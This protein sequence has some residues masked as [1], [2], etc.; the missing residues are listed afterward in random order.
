M[1]SIHINSIKGDE[2]LAKSVY[3]EDGR[4]LLRSGTMIRSTYIK[5]L[6]EM[7]IEYL[8]IQDADTEGIN[9]EEL[10]S[11]E[12]KQQGKQEVKKVFKDYIVS[13]RLELTKIYD[14]VNTIL[15]E[16]LN[17]KDT[18]FNVSDLR[19]KNE[20][21]YEHCMSVCILATSVGAYVFDT[22]KLR[23]LTL[24]A[25]LHDFGLM[26]VP[27]EIL[28]KPDKLSPEEFDLIKT[29]PQ[30]GYE[31]L[32]SDPEFSMISRNIVYMHHEK[33]D[34]SGYPLGVKGKQIHDTTKLVTICDMFDAMVT[35][36]PYRK[37]MKTY[38]S[39]ETLNA[40][41]GVQ[42]D[43]NLFEEFKKRVALYPVGKPVVLNNGYKGIVASQN[44]E[45]LSRP[46]VRMLYD[47]DGRK[48]PEPYDLDLTQELTLF[49]QDVID[50]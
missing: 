45:M 29:H 13:E 1:R 12:T 23:D 43:K 18:I 44:G 27:E 14:L 34:G 4:V 26:F 5:K 49:I 41:S 40:M 46:I 39:F 16:I 11:E 37:Q 15:D 3:D 24:G 33:C 19:S 2:V 42:I 6:I 10:V 31:I 36:K 47:N 25:L 30:V 20:A 35:T 7:G 22:K 48:I 38:E 9:L 21:L 32:I 50:L 8:Y 28:D 17:H